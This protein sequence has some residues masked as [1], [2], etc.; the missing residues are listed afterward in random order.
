[1]S[2]YG[3]MDAVKQKRLN[4][5]LM[6]SGSDVAKKYLNGKKLMVIT[7]QDRLQYNN[8]KKQYMPFKMSILRWL[9]VTIGQPTST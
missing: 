7:N 2:F 1:M 6:S 8:E 4:I 9:S 3:Q 5:R